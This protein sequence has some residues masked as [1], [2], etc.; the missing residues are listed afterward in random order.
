MEV[1]HRAYLMPEVVTKHL[2]IFSSLSRPPLPDIRSSGTPQDT[3]YLVLSGETEWCGVAAIF[4][5]FPALFGPA[6]EKA[7]IIHLKL[8]LFPLPSN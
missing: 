4:H 8:R 2:L 1:H 6:S 3:G 7:L 5:L